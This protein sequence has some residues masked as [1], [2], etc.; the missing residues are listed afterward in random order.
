MG[1]PA[2]RLRSRQS[3]NRAT[4]D[5]CMKHREK[6]ADLSLYEPS[7]LGGGTGS[8]GDRFKKAA[9]KGNLVSGLREAMVD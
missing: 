5:T 3:A 1:G 9:A 4:F 6:L 8:M 7:V 2:A